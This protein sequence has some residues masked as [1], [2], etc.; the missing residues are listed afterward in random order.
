MTVL[1]HSRCADFLPSPVVSLNHGTVGV[2]PVV[3]L[4]ALAAE[5]RR[6]EAD[7]AA[8]LEGSHGWLCDALA[9]LA[10]GLGAPAE[11]CAFVDNTTVGVNALLAGLRL[12]VGDEVVVTGHT[13]PGVRHA[14][15]EVVERVGARLV[16][17]ALPFPV[18]EGLDLVAAFEAALTSRT[19]LVIVDHITSGTGLLLPVDAIVAAV[20]ARGVPCL[21]D[22][23]H[24]YGQ[25]AVDLVR[26]GAAA[27]VGNLHKWAY[28]PRATALLHVGALWPGEVRHPVRSLYSATGPSVAPSD[29]RRAL[30]WPGTRDFAPWLTARRG[31][32]YLEDLGVEEVRAWQ[33]TVAL[34]MEQRLCE[35]WRV[36]PSAPSRLRAA[37]VTV[38]VPAGVP[39]PCTSEGAAALR[40]HLRRAHQR[41]VACFAFGGRL[42]LRLSAA[43]YSEVSD[44][45]AVVDG[46]FR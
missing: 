24:A 10:A 5:H 21:V 14:A 45:E 35:A 7:P 12:Q 23:A 39:F 1:G 20:Q 40:G 3:V 22:A 32:Q 34:G 2:T 36:S 27:T 9:P 26:T 31:W 42:W 44:V 28:A 46:V 15:L 37:M 25:V 16:E 33:R 11:E 29:W 30:H 4:E 38:Q 13:Y 8:M 19:R 6:I 41:E 18:P 17:A 43:V